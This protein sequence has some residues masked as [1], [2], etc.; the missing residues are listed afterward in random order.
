[1]GQKTFVKWKNK[2]TQYVGEI[3]ISL[4]FFHAKQICWPNKIFNHTFFLKCF[5]AKL[6]SSSL[7]M[8]EKSF[9]NNNKR[10][11][12]K[13]LSKNVLQTTLF[14][15]F[16]VQKKCEAKQQHKHIFFCIGANSVT[17]EYAYL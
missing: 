9:T 16:F 2:L 1:M 8:R 12:K 17:R 15:H 13:V 4:R 10:L 7:R 11:H 6:F 14:G 3:K 5:L